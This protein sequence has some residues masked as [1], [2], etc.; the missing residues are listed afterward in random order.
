MNKTLTL[1]EYLDQIHVGPGDESS[2]VIVHGSTEMNVCRRYLES[3]PMQNYLDMV[4][5]D[6][7]YPYTTIYG[8]DTIKIFLADK[9][10]LEA[11]GLPWLL[12]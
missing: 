2:F 1:R 12:N 8:V 4:I 5:V 3:T 10:L 9:A 6:F 11:M 7:V